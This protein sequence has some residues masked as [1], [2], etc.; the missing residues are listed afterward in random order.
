MGSF[1]LLHWGIVLAI[2]MLV[3]GTGK[4]KNMGA[5]LGAAVR[6]FKEGVKGD[7]ADHTAAPEHDEPLALGVESGGE[8]AGAA[9]APG[10][11]RT[12]NRGSS[13]ASRFRA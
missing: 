13:T 8:V 12:A 9:A 11:F 10:R 5:D 4:L 1:S 6:G 7:P 3:F 2:V